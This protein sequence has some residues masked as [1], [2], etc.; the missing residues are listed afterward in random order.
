VGD[1]L[2][3]ALG[4]VLDVVFGMLIGLLVGD[5]VL[6]TPCVTL[7]RTLFRLSHMGEIVELLA[8]SIDGLGI[9]ELRVRSMVGSSLVVADVGSTP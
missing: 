4:E 8:G 2:G 1:W 3:V 5:L 6:R 9:D 7:S